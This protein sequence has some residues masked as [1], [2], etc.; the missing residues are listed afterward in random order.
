MFLEIIG[1]IRRLLFW[2]IGISGGAGFPKARGAKMSKEAGKQTYDY[3]SINTVSL[4]W[5]LTPKVKS[6]ENFWSAQIPLSPNALG[7]GDWI[8][9]G[10][11]KVLLGDS[12]SN[13]H[14]LVA[15]PSS[16]QSSFWAWQRSHD[17]FTYEMLYERQLSGICAGTRHIAIVFVIAPLFYI[18]QHLQHYLFHVTS[19][20]CNI[21]NCK[22][23]CISLSFFKKHLQLYLYLSAISYKYCIY[24]VGFSM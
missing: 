7:A 15:K 20:S 2:S 24:V 10:V 16:S 19:V 4:G 1:K 17:W 23:N 3:L 9:F 22:C 21:C 18:L 5:Y 11:N 13:W 6:S 12:C 14:T 8:G